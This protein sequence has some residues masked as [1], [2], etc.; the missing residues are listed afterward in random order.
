MSQSHT[1]STSLIHLAAAVAQ[2]PI[3]LGLIGPALD[4]YW[5]QV[6][7]HNSLRELGKTVTYAR[8][9]IPARI[10]VIAADEARMRN[11]SDDVIVELTSNV[12]SGQ[13]PGI[14]AR[15]FLAQGK[16]EAAIRRIR[17]RRT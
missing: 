8:D 13:I 5:T 10:G 16:R 2:A 9:D 7:Y 15:L 4:G 6:I 14:L 12:P 3:E 1:P 11:L 17:P